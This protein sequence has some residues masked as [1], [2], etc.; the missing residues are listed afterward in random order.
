MLRDR[1][2]EH[3]GG[4]AVIIGGMVLDIHANP[5]IPPNPGTTTPGKVHYVLGGVARNVAECMSKLGAKPYMISAIGLD[6]AGNLLLEQW[7]SAGLPTEGILKD[8][9]IE[10]PV[11]CIIFDANGES[12]A[13]VASVEAI[14]KHLTPEWILHFKSTIRFA[15]LLMVDANLN[16]PSLEASCKIAADSECPVWFEPVSVAKSKRITSIVKYVTF[17]S[18]NEDELIAMANALSG[19]DV[20]HPLK[21][22]HNLSTISLFHM[23]KPAIW[24]LLEKGIQVVVLTLGS[25]GV[26]LCS[27][28]VRRCIKSPVGKTTQ[29][30][31]G[32]QLYKTIM[33]KCPPNRF[34]VLEPDT[35]SRLFAVHFPSLS[36]SVVRLTGAGDCLV[37]GTLTSICAGLDIMQSISVGIA[38]AKATVEVEANVPSAFSLATIADDAK[39]VYSAAKLLFHQSML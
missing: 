28:G 6:M 23:L 9:N 3:N 32:G 14:E 7:K 11:V 29:T 25:E 38:V 1:K 27:K 12:A 34:G 21:T 33:Q 20:F 15:P 17:T 19:K 16:L 18:P 39:T 2:M 35:S 10:T 36:A 22:K 26:I 31:Y 30:G 24:V 37:G 8:K 5:S 4:E 13:A